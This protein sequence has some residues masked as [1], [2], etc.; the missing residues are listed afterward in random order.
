MMA[1]FTFCAGFLLFT[2][3]TGVAEFIRYFWGW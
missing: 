2:A 3:L 1:L